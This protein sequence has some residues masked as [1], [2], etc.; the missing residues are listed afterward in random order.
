MNRIVL[1]AAAAATGLL[2]TWALLAQVPPQ[3]A[4]KV[5]GGQTEPGKP[6]AAPAEPRIIVKLV[7]DFES[8]KLVSDLEDFRPVTETTFDATGSRTVTLGEDVV[9]WVRNAHVDGK[10]FF[11]RYYK[12]KYIGRQGQLEIDAKELGPGE[13]TIQPGN[14]RFTVAA[15]ETITSPDTEIRIDGRAVMLRLHRVTVYAVDGAKSGPPEFRKLA[16]DMGLFCLDPAFRIEPAN[17]PDP[18][19]TFDPQKPPEAGKAPPPLMN[20]LS[21]QKAF[22]P[23]SVW[24]PANEVGQG[25]VLY[26]SWQAFRLTPAGK[27]DMAAG[28]APAV[29]GVEVV[30]NSIVIPHRRFSGAVSTIGGISAGVANVPLGPRMLLSATLAPLKLRAGIKTPAEDFFLSVD[31]DFTR[32]PFKHFVADNRG[33]DPEAIRLLAVEWD[34]PVFERGREG[35]LALR[36]FETPGKITLPS[37]EVRVEISS[38]SPSLPTARSW[39]PVEV[40]GW[41]NTRE[42]GVLRFRVPE[43]DPGFVAFRVQVFNKGDPQPTT[44]LAAEVLAAVV[45]ADQQGSASFAAN[46]GRNAFLAG[47]DILI[48]LVI[49]SRQPRQA[50]ERA[51][52]LHHPDGGEEPFKVADTGEPWLVRAL[53]IPSS[54]SAA[55]APGR[56]SLTVRDLPANVAVTPFVFDLAGRDRA[57]LYH[58]VKPSKYTKPMND[59]EPSHM[60]GDKPIDLDRAMHTLA[61]LGYNRV[62]L[63]SYMVNHHLRNYTWREDLAAVDPRLPSSDSVFTPSPRDQIL[64]ACV[65]EQLQYSDVWLSYNDFHLPRYI[66]GYINTSERWI[67]REMQAMRHSPALDGMMLYDEMYQQ[68]VSGIVETHQNIFPRIRARLATDTLGKSP[69]QIEAAFSRY[70]QRPKDQRD[71]ETLQLMLRYRDWE[72]HG[73]A[74]YVNRVVK[75]GKEIL[76]RA[77]FGTYTRTWAAPGT[78]DDI[79]HGYPPDLFKN[80]DIISHVHYADNSTCW[81]SIPIV[82]R[83]LRTGT[84]KTLYVNMP[85]LH[86]VRSKWDGQYTRQMAFALMAQGANGISQW[87]LPHS[88]EDGPNTSIVQ[89]AETTRHLNRE[90][91]QP[92]GELID[93]T[94]EGYRKIGIVSTMN[95]HALSA[96]KEIGTSHQTE[97]IWVACWRLGY[98]ALFLREDDLRDKLE[99]YAVIFVPGIRFDGELNDAIVSRLREAIAAGTR[100]VVEQGSALNLPGITRLEDQAFNSYYVGNYFPTW[101]DDELKKVYQRSQPITDYLRRKFVEWDVEPAARGDFTVGPGWRDGGDIHYLV[102]A[103]FEDPDYGHAVKQQMAKPVL[104]PLRVPARH[105]KVAYDLLLQKPV[106]LQNVQDEKAR[107]ETGLTLDMR[108]IQGAFLAFL[109]ERPARLRLSYTLGD[110][111]DRVR[112]TGQLVGE[113]G[114]LLDGVFPVR[115][116]LSDGHASRVF[117]R[118]LGRGLAPELDLP[119]TLQG[120]N[121]RVEVREA[122]SGL[123]AAIQVAGGKTDGP[124]LQLVA[125]DQPFVPYPAEVKEFMDH[126]KKVVIVP[127]PGL[128][129]VQPLAQELADALKAK[130]VETRIAPEGTV[131]RPPSGNPALEDPLMDGFHSWR[132]G[133]EVIGPAMVVDE[134]VI[135]LGGKGSSLLVDALA[136]YGYLSVSLAG[137]PGLPVRPSIQLAR[138]GFHFRYDTLCLLAND[139]AGIKQSMATILRPLPVTAEPQAIAFTAPQTVE[140]AERT[141]ATPAASYMDSNEMVLDMQFD[142]AGNAYVITWGHG[143]NLYS[144][145]PDGKI[146]FSLFLPEMGADRLQVADDRV[147][148]HTAAGARVYQCTLDGKPIS[149]ARLNMDP[150]TTWDDEYELA[151]TDFLYLSDK[152]LLLHNMGDRMRVLDDEDHIVNEWQGEPFFDK[153]VSDEIFHRE[154]HAYALSPD[155]QRIAQV[156]SSFYFAKRGYEDMKVYDTHLV[157]RD[158]AGKL[159]YEFK[160][161]DNGKEVEALLTW[162]SGQPG[163]VV[164]VRDQRWAFDAELKLTAKSPYEAGEHRLGDERRLVRDGHAFTYY[165]TVDHIR[166][167]IGPLET[168][169]T[170]AVI[171]ADL[172]QIAMLDENGR[173]GVYRATDGALVAAWQVPQ[174]GHVLRFT[175]NG[176]LILLGTIPGRVLAFDMSGALKWQV[177]LGDYNDVLGQKLA[178]VDPSFP[179]RT[180]RLWPVSRD[181]PGELDQLARMG[182]NRLANADCE[183]AGGWQGSV[184]Y[185]PEGYKSARS[186]KVGSEVVSQEV[187]RY[188]GEHIT[189]VLE[190]YHRSAKTGTAKLLAGLMTE[191]AFPDSVAREFEAGPDWRYGRIVIKNGAACRK[192]VAGFS[193]TGGEVLV[194]QVQL[195]RVRFPSV[196]YM[197]YEPLYRVK[198]VILDNPLFADK[199]AP[200]GNLREQA[201]NR[202]IVEMLRTG[203]LNLLESAFLQNGR[204]NEL[205]SNWYIQPVGHDPLVSMGL[206]EPRW[207]SMVGLYFNAYDP[208]NVTPHFDIFA[209][210][211]ETQKDRLVASVR[212]NGQLFRLVKF[213]PVKTPMIKIRL[214]N[215]IAR[216]RTLSEVEVY[217]PLSGREGAP[218]FADAEGQNTYMG[219]FSRVDK[220]AKTLAARY[221]APT[222]RVAGNAVETMWAVPAAQVLASEGKAYV[223]RSF[224]FHTA[225][226][227]DKPMEELYW[228]RTGGTGCTPYG[229]IYG[230]LLLRNGNDGRLY[231]LNPESGTGLWSVP[232]G[233]RLFGSGVC[234]QEDLYAASDT[235][236]VYQVDIANGSIMREAPLT[237]GVFGSLATDDQAL[238]FAT[239]DGFLHSYRAS[240]LVE[241]WKAPVAPD[242]DSTPAVDNGIVY[243]ADQKGTARAIQTSDGK[244]LWQ[245][246]LGDEFAR[247]PVV[248]PQYVAYGCR[249]GTLTVLNRA[250]GSMRWTRKVTTRFAYEPLCV[251]DQ[252]LYLDQGKARLAALA[253]GAE[254]PLQ[255]SGMERGQRAANTHDL[256]PGDLSMSMSYYHGTLFFI[257][258]DD[259][260]AFQINY[261]WH[262]SGGRVTVLKPEPEPAGGAGEKQP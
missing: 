55:L 246:E 162:P 85:L 111:G 50:A 205:S 223:A 237:A 101:L 211:M 20:L 84:G 61:G 179:D 132:G 233:R 69:S 62:D 256:T 128:P 193:A 163:P 141:P 174:L 97:G 164:C 82:A 11:E 86:E 169:P 40:L 230:G 255:W 25:Y 143:K 159:L 244:A 241:L 177:R 100:V 16:S 242:T 12:E 146:R 218:S 149:Q 64:N 14:H 34:H 166:C 165:D 113:S 140:S 63:M 96:F 133:Q 26:P 148:V 156:E 49:R 240:D 139:V 260:D 37:P 213:P 44:G 189:W 120:T 48:D 216:L 198:P 17:L 243:F 185:H 18:R 204:L 31:N 108:R 222:T 234:I 153:D 207:I 175:D 7:A 191:S 188:L 77:R 24:L 127:A 158:L 150:G 247:C 217:G 5:P 29:P 208:A 154:L 215:S 147:L 170:H 190:F 220:R 47:E 21:H 212:H 9:L 3:P 45:M 72:Q 195:R 160:D 251:G 107:P 199:Y 68:A 176:Q 239:A 33:T 99:G 238:F 250:D 71:P 235:G 173:L 46:K 42:K 259:H 104:L 151:S 57:S 105:G 70:L 252:I 73:W 186:L 226:A 249:G 38:Y 126:V 124:D 248:T 65:R 257:P 180:E 236:A 13:H 161:I 227:L 10:F 78:S 53:R 122:I 92:F 137:G 88:F 90:I 19:N 129:G 35:R 171:S 22:Y 183:G 121:Y 232:L 145:T 172:S 254:M 59:L 1:L 39:K 115:I 123:T 155:R 58:I 258:R 110:G 197:L 76:P 134:D 112:L 103:N 182:E 30:G 196:N 109:P 231:C 41:E 56:Y 4:P 117:F 43:V 54:H 51:V 79:Y 81:V 225:Y 138:K 214:V 221:Q 131:Y 66:E 27:V 28:G 119:R 114:K 253:D 200:A 89:G 74:D 106:E 135:L 98:P 152:H 75:V 67:A 210:D 142:K 130:G 83:I 8:G 93:R 125:Q 224:G 178:L 187:T 6:A 80:L 261:G 229:S 116:T 157:I 52:V 32:M 192:L 87:G 202:I 184:N 167:R 102:M 168:M 245:V 206:K 228:G 201:P 262:N 203:A 36:L 94:G 144:L 209:T 219:D 23:L 91:L 95:Q 118:V 181:E 60:Q 15:D 2:C 136:T 194:D